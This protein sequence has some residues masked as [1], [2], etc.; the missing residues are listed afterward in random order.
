VPIYRT[1]SSAYCLQ[2][3]G[4]GGY[5]SS[6]NV[7]GAQGNAGPESFRRVQ[8]G[9]MAP[10]HFRYTQAD[11]KTVGALDNGNVRVGFKRD[12]LSGI[13]SHLYAENDSAMNAEV[14]L[15]GALGGVVTRTI[16]PGTSEWYLDPLD[17]ILVTYTTVLDPEEGVLETTPDYRIDL[18]YPA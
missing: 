13:I 16:P 18:K 10:P 1:G 2:K 17:Q 14:T 11:V 12:E 3:W 8:P 9:I 7:A 6:Q 5:S 15:R 4:F